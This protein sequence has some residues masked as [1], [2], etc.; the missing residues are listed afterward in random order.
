[1]MQTTKR[2]L[3]ILTVLFAVIL[4]SCAPRIVHLEEIKS[5]KIPEVKRL[6][7]LVGMITEIEE[8]RGEQ[9]FIYIKLGRNNE[10]YKAGYIGF[11]YNDVKMTEKVAKFRVVK[12]YDKFSKGE[13][14]E[15]NY[16][17]DPKAIV[18]VEV[19]PRFLTK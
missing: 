5:E 7:P 17:I 14:L 2:I 9:K 10:W 18:S 6:A 19:D 11:V 13:I 16:T 1:M 8:V 3:K 15:L 12:L 4:F